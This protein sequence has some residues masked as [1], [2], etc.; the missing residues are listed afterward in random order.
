MTNQL[1]G[2][3]ITSTVYLGA[4]TGQTPER[5]EK[6][7]LRSLLL[8]PTAPTALRAGICRL[9]RAVT[10]CRLPQLSVGLGANQGNLK[11]RHHAYSSR[12]LFHSTLEQSTQ[13]Q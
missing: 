9:D 11:P 12:L 8:S 2:L 10:T 6:G 13:S 4:Q 1:R 3:E 7:S 5:D